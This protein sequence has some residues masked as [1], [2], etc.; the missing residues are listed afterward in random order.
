MNYSRINDNLNNS[1]AKVSV[2]SL[3]GVNEYEIT[4]G[5]TVGEF[6]ARYGLEGT[7]VVTEAGDT[8]ENNAILNNDIQIFISTPKK[9]G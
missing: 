2:I 6:K 7:K 3:A 1:S 5:M 9:N 8:L 4:A